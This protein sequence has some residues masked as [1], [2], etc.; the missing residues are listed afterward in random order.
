VNPP[1]AVDLLARWPD[2]TQRRY[3]QGDPLFREALDQGRVLYERS[4]ARVD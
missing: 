2:D 1:F 3:A 4:R